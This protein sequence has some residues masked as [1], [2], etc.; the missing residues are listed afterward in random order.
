MFIWYRNSALASFVSIVG[1]AIGLMGVMAFFEGIWYGLFLLIPAAA[2]VFGGM[3]ISTRKEEADILKKAAASGNGAQ[4][5]QG[6]VSRSAPANAKVVPAADTSS[7]AEPSRK[8]NKAPDVI[9]ASGPVQAPPDF[10]AENAGNEAPRFCMYCGAG[11]SGAMKFCPSCG[12]PVPAF[13]TEKTTSVPGTA[14]EKERLVKEAVAKALEYEG[15]QEYQAELDTILPVLPY[16]EN[17]PA[18]FIRAGYA[19]RQLGA[20]DK[21]LEYYNKA[22]ALDA[23]NAILLSNIGAALAFGGRFQEALPYYK[24]AVE[25]YEA[26]RDRYNISDQAVTYANYG[27]SLGKTGDM[28]NARAFLSKA[29]SCG[30]G[31]EMVNAIWSGLF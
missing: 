30:Y 5:A 6:T 31:K 13:S 18:P 8:E 22:L 24:R 27:Y 28:N 3:V 16:A 25:L 17:D 15:K 26:D 4:P 2:G 10:S 7:A 11:L 21:A 20:L 1:C 29:E 19:S 14:A 12:R 9:Y 23:N